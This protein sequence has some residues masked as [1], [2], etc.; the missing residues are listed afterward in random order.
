MSMGMLLLGDRR[1]IP[2]V[3]P[4]AASCPYA[5][6]L[7][8]VGEIGREISCAAE[9]GRFD[10]PAVPWP[11]CALPWMSATR[12]NLFREHL[13]TGRLEGLHT[14]FRLH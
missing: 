13:D 1:T 2:G 5:E 12:R 11:T 4:A 8:R 3:R 10:P 14:W 6:N 9:N 7:R